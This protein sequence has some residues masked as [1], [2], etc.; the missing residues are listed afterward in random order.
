MRE[1]TPYISVEMKQSTVKDP[2]EV[3]SKTHSFYIYSFIVWK[4]RGTKK[5]KNN[6]QSK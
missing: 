2:S 6:V 3:D 1:S 5:N 4:N